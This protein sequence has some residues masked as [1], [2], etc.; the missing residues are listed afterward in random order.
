MFLGAGVAAK[1]PAP[2][3]HLMTFC[4]KQD[5]EHAFSIVLV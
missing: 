3:S 4:K 5:L 1:M 2:W